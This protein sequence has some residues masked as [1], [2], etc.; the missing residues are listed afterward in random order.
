MKRRVGLEDEFECPNLLDF[1][2]MSD[3]VINP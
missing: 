3:N 1:G 2:S